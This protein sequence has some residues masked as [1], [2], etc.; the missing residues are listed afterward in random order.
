MTLMTSNHGVHLHA[1]VWMYRKYEEREV[2]M[3]NIYGTNQSAHIFTTKW[4]SQPN[5]K[6][7]PNKQSTPWKD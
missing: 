6:F 5:E 7:H 3:Y 1:W 2:C 4:F